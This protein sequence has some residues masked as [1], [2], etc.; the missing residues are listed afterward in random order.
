MKFEEKPIFIYED[1]SKNIFSKIMLVNNLT[2][3]DIQKLNEKYQELGLFIKQVR[4]DNFGNQKSKNDEINKNFISKKRI[5]KRHSKMTLEQLY[6]K[7][8]C[9]DPFQNKRE[10]L[11]L[12]SN[13][14][15]SEELCDIIEL[16]EIIRNIQDLHQDYEKLKT[17]RCFINKM[18]F[19]EKII[20][21]IQKFNKYLNSE[22]YPKIYSQMR[23]KALL[24]IEPNKVD[25]LSEWTVPLLKE[26]KAEME[27]A[28]I[29]NII[30]NKI[31]K[32]NDEKKEDNKPKEKEEKQKIEKDESI[33]DSSD[34]DSDSN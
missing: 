9:Y 26:F 34:S 20:M 15:G 17:K 10:N 19:K 30:K 11:R 29:S 27:I 1:T 32:S 5:L 2:L 28:A 31:G 14:L 21:Y 4:V 6:N 16:K 33:N 8:F 23:E 22:I 18:K 12:F 24:F 7:Y 25:D 3:K 13:E